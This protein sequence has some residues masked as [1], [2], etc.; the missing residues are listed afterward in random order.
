MLTVLGRVRVA[1]P[2]AAI[3]PSGRAAAA[4]LP[5]GVFFQNRGSVAGWDKGY[6]QKQGTIT[7]IDNPTYKGADAVA[8]TQTY[9]NETGGYHSEVIRQGAQSVGQDRYYGQAIYLGS[10]WRFHDQNV[11][12]QQFSPEDPE[13][14][15]LLMFVMGNK[16]QYGGLG[17]V[18]GTVGSIADLRG[19]WI[20]IVV[21]LKLADDGQG[22]FEVW[23]NGKKTA[24]STGITL[25]PSTART[26]RLVQ[27][28]L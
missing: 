14:P 1:G 21:R 23:L 22:A 3:T 28:H 9:I 26:I 20:R 13:G 10:D 8:A 27:R 25:L 19:T 18:S 17:A 24:S 11:T 15:W 6:A 4:D 16:I 2:L 12:F 5:E 7:T